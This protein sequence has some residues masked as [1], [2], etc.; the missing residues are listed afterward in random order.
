ML[1]IPVTGTGSKK[2]IPYATLLLVLINC[3]VYFFLQSGD[4]AAELDAY[5]YYE[6]SGLART[7]LSAYLHYKNL[8]ESKV[9][10]ILKEPKSFEKQLG[11]MFQDD[12][13]QYLLQQE[14]I[15]RLDSTEYSEWREE[16]TE[17]DG[18]LNKSV[19]HRYGYAPAKKKFPAIFTYMFL[20]GGIFH[21]IGNMVFLWLVGGLLELAAGKI[22]FLCG[23]VISGVFAS[24]LFGIV[25]PQS[26]SPLV[27]ASGAIAG[28]MGAYAIYF[29]RR[30]IRIFYSLGFY[31]SYARVPAL[32][33]LP[34]WLA[35]ECIQLFMNP[36]SNV[37]YMAH[38]GGLLSG[39]GLA[40]I[41]IALRGNRAD[42][43]FR[44]EEEKNKL[45]ELLD[46]GQ[47]KMAAL[48]LEEARKDMTK[49]LKLEAEHPIALRNLYTIDKTEPH[50]RNFQE[51][52]SNLLQ[53]LMKGNE[54]D[55]IAV[56]EEFG[57]LSGRIPSVPRITGKAAAIY[58]KK[59]RLPEADECIQTLITYSADQPNI[60]AGLMRLAR[61]Y[62]ED[63]QNQEA[64]RC[65]QILATKYG[66]SEEGRKAKKILGKQSG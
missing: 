38:I 53:L 47:K 45:E 31:F 10:E 51:S 21:L 39:S 8:N 11:K 4:R 7:E 37:A 36:D 20:H 22:L 26:T 28:L 5:T 46:K 64:R 49:V 24:L 59:N 34:F 32:A 61:A 13:F 9:R 17:F 23:Y 43:L 3:F 14:E 33:L 15:I 27:G 57:R 60:P 65:L 12:T 35:N 6:D 2:K 16:R 55:F 56:F 41:N 48:D 40:G 42:E 19:T 52:A 30:R 54:E 58:L 1:V 62:N 18:L 44:E 66:E 63:R 25:Y 29:W 50:S